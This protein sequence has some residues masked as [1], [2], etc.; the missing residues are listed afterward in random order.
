MRLE[1]LLY[2]RYLALFAVSD[3]GGLTTCVPPCDGIL[4]SITDMAATQHLD[5]GA[6]FL[7][8]RFK[9]HLLAMR[10]QPSV[11]GVDRH[12]GLA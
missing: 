8:Q 6:Q 7:P 11:V 5:F 10:M 2:Y 12:E 4:G 3:V 9:V 1:N